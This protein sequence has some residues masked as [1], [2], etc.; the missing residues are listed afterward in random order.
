M[1]EEIKSVKVKKIN[2]AFNSNEID[3]NIL[4]LMSELSEKELAEFFYLIEEGVINYNILPYY[5]IC[6][7]EL[8]VKNIEEK[9][10]YTFLNK[11]FATAWE[12]NLIEKDEVT[13]L[14]MLYGL[15]IMTT[16]IFE[17]IR[18]GIELNK[19]TKK[20][21]E[22]QIK[23]ILK[24]LIT[25]S[26]NNNLYHILT[27]I[28]EKDS[29]IVEE[30]DCFDNM[31][32]ELFKL[33]NVVELDDLIHGNYGGKDYLSG[34]KK[35]VLY[36]KQL[37]QTIKDNFENED[38]S[39]F[40]YLPASYKE[41]IIS[42]ISGKSSV[43]EVELKILDK[44][45]NKKRKNLIESLNADTDFDE[46]DDFERENLN[47]TSED[48][49]INT[50]EKVLNG[51]QK[52]KIIE[53]V[54]VMPLNKNDLILDSEKTETLSVSSILSRVCLVIFLGLALIGWGLSIKTDNN[55][56]V[57]HIKNI[58]YEEILSYK[59][60]SGSENNFDIKVK[61]SKGDISN[62]TV[63]QSSPNIQ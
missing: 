11:L 52:Q 32:K 51:R 34:N 35:D 63:E 28:D 12:H 56:E 19:K 33:S 21:F 53:K 45:K 16:D 41:L 37:R 13:L 36:E 49:I 43:K 59:L 26:E 54:N 58:T 14:K 3:E 24:E 6:Y 60:S 9:M 29:S 62:G 48:K 38:L 25:T 31:K 46:E 8:K 18:N 7:E 23:K 42:C 15:T 10:D 40:K 2:N 17:R 50:F 55:N 4:N 20:E 27:K 44:K 5:F 22:V 30:G 61:R 1:F 47:N 57:D 39:K